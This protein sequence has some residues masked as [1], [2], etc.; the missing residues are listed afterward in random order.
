MFACKDSQD[1]LTE[2]R[3]GGGRMVIIINDR[4]DVEG[5]DR[6]DCNSYK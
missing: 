4:V 6:V 2:E 3:I 1:G 5:R